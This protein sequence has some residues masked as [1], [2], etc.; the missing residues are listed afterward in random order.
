VITVASVDYCERCRCRTLHVPLPDG[1][2][3]CEHH[4]PGPELS[5]PSLEDA[6]AIEAPDIFEVDGLGG[7]L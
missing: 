6:N 4:P 7:R 2:R 3:A 5:P 1:A